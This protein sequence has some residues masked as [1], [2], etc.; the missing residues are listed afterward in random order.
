MIRWRTAL[1]LLGILLL[2]GYLRLGYLDL[3][4]FKLDEVTHCRLALE[5]L[6]GH[7]PVVGSTASVGI[8]KPAGM[9]YLLVLPLAVTRDPRIVT[10]FLAL[11]N[12][13]AVVSCFLLARR[14]FGLAVGLVS[15]LLFAVSPWAVLFSRKVF[16]ADA[17]PFFTVLLLA[18]LFDTLVGQKERRLIL[19]FVWLA[20]LLQITFSALALVPVMALLLLI[21]R[22]R[23]RWR[24]LLLGGCCFLVIFAPYLYRDF[25]QGFA[26]LK[27]LVDTSQQP[28]QFS[29]KAAQHALRIISGANLHSLA[30]TAFQEFLA[31]RLPLGWL[32]VLEMMLLLGGVLYLAAEIWH[33]WRQQKGSL[34]ART[35][36]YSILLIWTLVPVLIN[37]RPSVALHP[38]Y[39]VVL[40]PAPYIIIA[41]L[42]VRVWQWGTTLK[43]RRAVAWS[44]SVAL[45]VLVV[46]I[47]VW[48]VYNVLY[49]Y[50]FV[51][52]HDTAWGHGVPVKYALHAANTL[53]RLADETGNRQ[54]VILTKGD[55]PSR[56]TVPAVFR[57]LLEGDLSPRFVDAQKAVVFTPSNMD[58]IYCLAPDANDTPAAEWL[59]RFAV[60]LPEETVLVRGGLQSYRFYRLPAGAVARMMPEIA[61]AAEPA[62][63]ANGVTL[64]GHQALGEMGPGHTVRLIL[65]WIAPQGVEGVDY[66]FF[67][68]LV[69]GEG[70]RWGQEDGVGYRT[71]AWQAGD[72]IVSWFDV[73]IAAD[74]PPG[75]FWVRTG[76]YTYPDV[77]TVPVVDAQGQPVSDAVEWKP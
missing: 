15:G 77:A 22:A 49:L 26:N 54:V 32:D 33:D 20:C 14:Y 36:G 1:A 47:A 41:L 72:L 23:V 7:L 6:Q 19:A 21:Y 70:R 53:R 63:W 68:H 31:G 5:V 17:L 2:A 18:A 56:D 74:A 27:A 16:T 64:L 25:T 61:S 10:G 48:Q 65:W 35:V 40:Y 28:A 38:H 51:D 52:T 55:R 71:S 3:V 66:H 58:T 4:E 42:V 9:T 67:N 13:F 43:D 75:P 62:L 39:F 12:V 34:S 37:I 69:D 60:L 24:P 44:I 11:L 29:L 45:M 57:F 59:A 30:G 73:E 8:P 46:S 76:M 50:R